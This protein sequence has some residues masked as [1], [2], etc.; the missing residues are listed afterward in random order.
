MVDLTAYFFQSPYD[1]LGTVAEAWIND[2]R[3]LR[4][5]VDHC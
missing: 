4:E 5:D 2:G 3:E 1:I